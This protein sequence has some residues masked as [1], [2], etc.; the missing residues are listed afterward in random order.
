MQ[1]LVKTYLISILTCTTMGIGL[2]VAS[3]ADVIGKVPETTSAETRPL[4]TNEL[5]KIYSNRSWMWKDG[6]G[7]F[8]VSGRQFTAWTKNGKDAS[9][10]LGRWFLTD[11]GR[12]CF[13]ATWHA[14]SGN[15]EALTCF[16]HRTDGATISQRRLPDGEWYVF[17][18]KPPQAGDEI[19]K[20]KLGDRVAPRYEQNKRRLSKDG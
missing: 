19:L 8:R 10:A 9:Y 12:A 18:H 13:R 17:S 14:A 20:L 4:T 6:A 7:Y 5:L 1:S 3:A 11:P 16:E 15:A 2:Q